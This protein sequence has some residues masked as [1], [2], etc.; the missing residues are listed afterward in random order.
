MIPLT[1]IAKLHCLFLACH[2]YFTTIGIRPSSIVY[3]K[4]FVIV[5]IIVIVVPML[6]IVECMVLRERS[7]R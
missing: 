1:R 3:V 7:L 2:H 6:C 4:G 5:Y